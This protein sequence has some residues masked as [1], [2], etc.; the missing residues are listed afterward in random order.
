MGVQERLGRL[1]PRERRLLGVL[2]MVTLAFI[3]IGFP[4]ALMA[5]ASSKQ[6][7]NEELRDAI[8]AI[9]R[10]EK[11]LMRVE[12]QRLQV[13]S[14]YKLKAPTLA[15]WLDRLAR[16]QELDIPES[17]DR[18][19]VT[20]GKQFEE[21]STQIMFR[22]AG[23]G[24]LARFM[25]SVEQAHYPVQISKLNIRKRGTTPDSFDVEMVVSA[26]DRKDTSKKPKTTKASPDE[27][28]RAAG[29][30]DEE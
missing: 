19:V 30:S 20:R 11:S 26:F 27:S 29:S 9:E 13:Q 17:Q 21:R 22:R 16:A 2:V 8:A 10:A 25:E 4:A 7:E 18:A 28:S 15:S 24:K 6:G 5:M 14:R 23:L 12:E 1:E 3:V